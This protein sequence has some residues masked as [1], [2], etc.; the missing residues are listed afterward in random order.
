M[1]V[2]PRGSGFPLSGVPYAPATARPVGSVDLTRVA[3][4]GGASTLM[5]DASGL[6]EGNAF[7][8][9]RYPGFWDL[10]SNTTYMMSYQVDGKRASKQGIGQI[11]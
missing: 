8:K 7:Q 10:Q 11:R 9:R 3:L 5:A 6:I 4:Q 1:I 2:A